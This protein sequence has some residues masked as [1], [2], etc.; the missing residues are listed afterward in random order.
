MGEG[1]REGE[2]REKGGVGGSKDIYILYI[3]VYTAVAL[4]CACTFLLFKR[5]SCR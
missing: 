1:G 4:A 2:S 3:H 5:G